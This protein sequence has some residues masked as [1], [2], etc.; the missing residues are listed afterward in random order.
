MNDR[1]IVV[2]ARDF[3]PLRLKSDNVVLIGGKRSN[4]WVE[5]FEGQMNFQYVYEGPHAKTMIRNVNPQ[6][7]EQPLYRADQASERRIPEG[8]CIIARLPNLSAKGKAMLIAGTETEA[9]EAGGEF[10]TSDASLTQLR[11][12][13][14]LGQR[15]PFPDFEALLGTTRV[16][17]ASPTA[18]LIA[19]RRH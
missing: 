5:L 14:K 12:G 15:E 17:G 6:A 10:I 4:P 1:L 2:H 16:G 11:R 18:R 19:V 8:Y 7:G 9:T 13:L 3:Q